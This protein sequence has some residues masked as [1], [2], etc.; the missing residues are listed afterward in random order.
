[1]PRKMLHVIQ[2]VGHF[3]KA[4]FEVEYAYRLR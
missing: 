1:M 4:I 2:R 3:V